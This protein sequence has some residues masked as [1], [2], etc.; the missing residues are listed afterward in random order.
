MRHMKHLGKQWDLEAK[1]KLK[2]M[3]WRLYGKS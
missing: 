2:E 1:N 3:T